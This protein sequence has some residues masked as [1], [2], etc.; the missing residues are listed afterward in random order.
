MLT[1]AQKRRMIYSSPDTCV[2]TR[3]QAGNGTEDSGSLLVQAPSF[4][5]WLPGAQPPLSNPLLPHL[6]P[7]PHLSRLHHLSG[8]TLSHCLLPPPP[9]THT[10]HPPPLPPLPPGD[11]APLCLSRRSSIGMGLCL[12]DS[13]PLFT[14]VYPVVSCLPF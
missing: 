13:S 8:F 9:T 2:K 6:R 14:G 4:P 1:K 5:Q 12:S 10:P 11:L 7:P 3:G